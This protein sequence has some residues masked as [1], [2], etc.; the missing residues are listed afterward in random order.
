[1]SQVEL[2]SLGLKNFAISARYASGTK[3]YEVY[4]DSP[5]IYHQFSLSEDAEQILFNKILHYCR[6]QSTV[7]DIGAGT[8]KLARMLAPYVRRVYALEPS[9]TFTN[10]SVKLTEA[11]CLSNLIHVFA[12]AEKIPLPS[13]SVDLATMTW[14]TFCPNEA[15]REIYRVLKK[16]GYAIRV[17]AVVKDDLTAF[18]PNLDEQVLMRTNTWFEQQGFETAEET[19]KV[20]FKNSATA[21]RILQALTGV[22]LKRVKRELIHKVVFQVY[23]HN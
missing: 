5:E 18:Y 14:A 1:M 3:F 7:L 8:G 21:R 6:Q 2:E 13:H 16:G 23:R 19:I 4:K 22:H 12:P 9:E 11:S 20:R 15:L 10:Y 17:G